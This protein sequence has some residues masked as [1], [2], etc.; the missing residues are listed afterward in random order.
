MRVEEVGPALRC[1]RQL[2][3][4]K[5]YEV[6]RRAGITKAMLSAYERGQRLPSLRSMF[7]V[8]DALGAHL[9]HVERAAQR[10]R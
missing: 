7:R 6:A 8:L 4:L 3:D 5:Q 10:L 2:R 1:L 9:A